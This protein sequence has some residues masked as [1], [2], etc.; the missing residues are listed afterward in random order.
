MP[1]LDFEH[2]PTSRP[3]GRGHDA[4]AG[5]PDLAAGPPA[6]RPWLALFAHDPESVVS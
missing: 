3:V 4:A 5:H 1:T 2:V 6:R